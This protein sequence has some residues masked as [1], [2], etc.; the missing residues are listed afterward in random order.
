MSEVAEKKQFT[1]GG[2]FIIE[3][4]DEIFIPENHDEEQA[5]FMDVAR[6][7]I[8]QHIEPNRLK[9]EKQENNISSDLME[10]IGELGLLC[11]HMPEAYDGLA[12]DVN[13]NT[14][15]SDVLG[16][17]GSFNT[18]LAA[19]TGIGMLPIL[20]YGTEEHKKKYLPKLGSGEWKA[21][22]CL[23]EPGS[24]SDALSAKTVAHLTADGKHYEISGQKM[25]ISNA[26]FAKVFI[27]FA[28]VDGD[29]FTGFVVE[30][31]CDGMTMGEEEDK[32]GIKGSSTRQVYFEKVKVPVENVLGEVGKGHL[33]AFNTLNIGRFKLGTM[34]VGGVKQVVNMATKY[35]NERIQFKQPISNFGAIQYKIAEMVV[36][37]LAVESSVYR[38][39]ELMNE[40]AKLMQADGISYG[41]A[42]RSA[43]EEYAIECSIIK[44]SGSET[45]DYA[46]DENVQIHGGIGF[47]EEYGAARAYR[48]NRITRI[49][50][51][52]NEI[53]RLLIVDMI[54]KRAMK[55]KLDIVGP[56]WEVQKELKGMPKFAD[57]SS[58]LAQETKAVTE[59]KKVILMVA[60]AAAK[61]QMEGKLD[62]KNEQMLLTFV[63]DIII[64]TFNAESMLLRVSKLK[65]QGH[66]HA[67]LMEEALKIF[68]HDANSRIAK[69]ALDAVS[70][71]TTGDLHRIFS[72]GIQRFTSYPAVNV[73]EGRRKIAKAIIEAGEYIFFN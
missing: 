7:F 19:H 3:T 37:N 58:P 1:Q 11:A 5:M 45:A 20:Y 69:N 38:T 41:E 65:K 39:S 13:T 22:Y 21:A 34:C 64:D 44:V 12:L 40:Y 66:E 47:S 26:G 8:A 6:S 15:I 67:D 68:I 35:A 50:E 52:T 17:M 9:I 10:T 55:G 59:F 32:L 29:K 62:L 49:Y 23:T 72:M 71:F 4:P 46:V 53:N 70:S 42:K 25:W 27:V 51:G 43:A 56:A 48:D 24:G 30:G 73:I 2:A 16:P 28:Q 33:I 18:T 60:G 57:L 63:S 31:P 14:L 61:E 36:R 54:L